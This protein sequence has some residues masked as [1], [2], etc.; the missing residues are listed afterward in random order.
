MKLVGVVGVI[1][2]AISC[3]CVL[4]A[5]AALGDQFNAIPKDLK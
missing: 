5:N 3:G 2:L 1:V 4:E